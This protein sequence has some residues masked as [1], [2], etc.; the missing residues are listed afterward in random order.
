[1]QEGCRG[2]I[3]AF[4]RFVEDQL[5]DPE[6]K[7]KFAIVFRTFGT[8]IP[9]I[10]KEWN[11]YCSGSHPYEQPPAALGRLDGTGPSGLDLRLHMPASTAMIHRSGFS[12]DDLA[13]AT[14]SGGEDGKGASEAPEPAMCYQLIG[15]RALDG[16]IRSR[17]ESGHRC[18]AVR[19][20]YRFW[21][22]HGERSGA[23][24]VV[25]VDA[26]HWAAA[27][28]GEGAAGGSAAKPL[29]LHPVFFDDN[30][31]RRRA[32]I[33]DVRVIP[34]AGCAFAGTGSLEG[35]DGDTDDEA[36]VGGEDAVA[37]GRVPFGLS[38]GVVALRAE[39]ADAL[40]DVS[41]FSRELQAAREMW[42]SFKA[43]IAKRMVS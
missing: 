25:L 13:V 11:M 17:I 36:A 40:R 18:L 35:D 14:V 12:G 26:R 34:A 5:Q 15:Y 1:M 3:P 4:F 28:A 41:Y 6:R 29:E 8:D 2:L 43:A 37:E 32:K 30:I 24:K 23:G 20:C 9:D 38:R 22:D 42:P 31:L 21:N 27:G 33:V 39:I 19:D 16:W 10:G 7:D